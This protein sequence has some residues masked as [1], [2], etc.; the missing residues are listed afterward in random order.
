M[1]IIAGPE[2]FLSARFQNVS[3]N[4]KLQLN[5]ILKIMT[6]VHEIC[7]KFKG[8]ESRTFPIVAFEGVLKS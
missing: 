6:F 8:Y 7:M 2:S 1:E 5:F 3:N 4:L